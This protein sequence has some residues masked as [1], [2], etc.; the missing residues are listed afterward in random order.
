MD[1]SRATE[2]Q[3]AERYLLGELPASE[4]EDFERHFFECADCAQAVEAGAEFIANA[5]AVLGERGARAA[6]DRLPWKSGEPFWQRLGGWWSLPRLVPTAAAAALA[7]AVLYQGFVVIPGLRQAFDNPRALPAFQ[8][9]GASRGAGVQ[10]RVPAGTPAFSLAIDIPPDV[11]FAQYLCVVT[12]DGRKVFG[13]AA[14]APG[15]GQPITILTPIRALTAGDYEFTVYGLTAD[16]QQRDKVA[17]SSFQ[18]QFR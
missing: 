16:G 4:A 15:A 9:I 3:A 12:R 10:I 6:S 5:R 13:V 14:P 2:V 17:G 18:F 1:H 8:L 7:A 11:H